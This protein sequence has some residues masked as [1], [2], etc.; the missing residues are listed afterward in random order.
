MPI[1][2]DGRL[3]SPLPNQWSTEPCLDLVNTRWSDHVGSGEFHD[4]LPE[5]VWRRAFLEHWGYRVDDPDDA[6]AGTRMARLR[7][8]LRAA[9]ESYM[10]S[11]RLTPAL[12]RA[13][14][15]EINR[16]PLVL[17]VVRRNGVE[18]LTL[19]RAGDAWDVALADVATSAVRLMGERRLVK[20]CANPDCTWVFEDESRSGSRRWCDV[21]ICGSLINVRRHRAAG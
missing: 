16:A 6:K 14:E 2:L 8:L 13:L 4:R 3:P 11:G 19:D 21:S 15:T 7:K 17:R 18:G 5:P 20:V 1:T 9:L 12:R 10:S